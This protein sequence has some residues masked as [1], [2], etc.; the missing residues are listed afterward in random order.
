M[1]G[2]VLFIAQGCAIGRV[3]VAPG[4]FGS[5]LGLI[6]FAVLILTGSLVLWSV[7]VLLGIM[8]AIW[9]CG[10]AEVLLDQP[11]PGSVVLDEIVAVPLC[12]AGW[13]VWF[14]ATEGEFPSASS[15][16]QSQ[17]LLVTAAVFLAFRFFDVLKPWP[18]GQSQR[19]SGGWGVVMDDVLAAAYVNLVFLMALW[20]IGPAL[21]G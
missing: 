11:D 20:F 15:F 14:A 17:S 9:V 19:L 10:R 5:L 4:T 18:V 13:I 21:T 6:W 3:P 8:C 1:R 7:G 2:I 12:F 16:F